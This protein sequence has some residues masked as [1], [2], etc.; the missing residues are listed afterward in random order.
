MFKK[1]K[2]EANRRILKQ[3]VEADEQPGISAY[4]GDQAVAWCA[5]ASRET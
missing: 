5:I 4:D 2:G 3:I 1:T